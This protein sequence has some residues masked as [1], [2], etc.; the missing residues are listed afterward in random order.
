MHKNFALCLIHYIFVCLFKIFYCTIP[1]M[2][3][4]F[5]LYKDNIN[6][7]RGVVFRHIKATSRKSDEKSE[8]KCLTTKVRHSDAR[9]ALSIQIC[10]PN[11]AKSPAY[12][13][14]IYIK[15]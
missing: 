15:F 7:K 4:Y 3:S 14:V 8:S 12:N 11:I 9:D 5:K 1:Q 13:I 6:V 2:Q 10:G